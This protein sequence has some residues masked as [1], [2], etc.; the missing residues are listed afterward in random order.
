MVQV[1]LTQGI[2]EGKA[3]D[4]FASFMG[5]P[6]AAPPVG[7][8]RFAPPGPAPTWEGVRSAAE[9]GPASLQGESSVPVNPF[10]KN[11]HILVKHVSI[12]L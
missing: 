12:S 7:G 10:L 2:L 11:F 4:G 9:P 5:I 6:F 3:G 1:N 8:A